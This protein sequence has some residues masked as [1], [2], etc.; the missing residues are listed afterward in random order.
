VCR[1]LMVD[2]LEVLRAGQ[3]LTFGDAVV[4]DLGVTLTRRKL[5]RAKETAL[6]E[7]AQ[8]Q[9]WSA[10]GMFFI[11]AQKDK[12]LYASMSY[13]DTP[14]AHLLEHL[15]RLKFKNTNRTLSALLN[16][17]APADAAR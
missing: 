5:F 16:P 6:A 8:L 12:K 3:T 2:I 1:R 4:N 11:G 10:N 15:I 7:W 14:N 9:I 17:Q 13:I